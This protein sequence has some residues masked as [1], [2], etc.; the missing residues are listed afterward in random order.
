[1]GHPVDWHGANR[2]L[3]PPSNKD[4]TSISS[5]RVFTNGIACVSC[6]AL[7]P[8]DLEEINRTGKIFVSSFSGHTQSPIFVGNEEDTR[9]LIADYGVWKKN[10]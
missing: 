4:E 5:M 2:T 3:G 7:S 6:W 10:D 1:M 9:G 8:S